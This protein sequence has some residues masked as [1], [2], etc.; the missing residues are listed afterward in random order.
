MATIRKRG[1]DQYQ[2]EIRRRGYT[3]EVKTFESKAEA[4]A[5]ARRA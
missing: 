4:Q 5:W 1:P 3:R 2:V